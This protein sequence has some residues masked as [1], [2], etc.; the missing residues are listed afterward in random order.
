M[1]APAPP[2]PAPAPDPIPTARP[3]AKPESLITNLICNVAIPT[4]IL[5]WFSGDRWLGPKWGL[6]VALAF[7][8]G[9]GLYDFAA[10]RRWNFISIIG[11]TSVLVSGGFGLLKLGG[12]WFAAKDAAIPTIIGLA[13]LASAKAKTPLMTELLYNP[14][15]IDVEKVDA[16]LAARGTQAGFVALL[17]R[18]TGLL[19]VSFFVSAGLN[20]GLA[21]YLLRSPPGTEAFNA[22]LGRMHLLSWPV[23]VLP[24]MAMMMLVLWNL[25]K[26]LE[27]LTS[28]DIDSIFRSPPEKPKAASS[29]S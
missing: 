19:S 29:R 27:A 8:T 26:G 7:P 10:R 16:A 11:F 24:S 22:E 21:R 20:Y 3:R 1:S 12:L 4:V 28:L 25:L 2:V 5:T 9:Y 18:S 15:V 6:L 23:I 14:H 13:V 17:R